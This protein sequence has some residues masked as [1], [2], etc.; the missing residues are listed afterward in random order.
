MTIEMIKGISPQG[1]Y[2]QFAYDYDDQY[3][4]TMHRAEDR[5]IRLALG[6]KQA[7][8]LIEICTEWNKAH[9]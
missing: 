7:E 8:K 2:D 1:A 9:P 6:N 5:V 3:L 4:S